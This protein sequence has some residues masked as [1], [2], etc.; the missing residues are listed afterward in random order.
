M[1]KKNTADIIYFFMRSLTTGQGMTGLT[2]E[3]VVSKDGAAQEVVAGPITELGR[4]QYRFEG[5]A[6][7][8]NGNSLGFI[9]YATGALDYDITIRTSPVSFSEIMTPTNVSKIGHV[10]QRSV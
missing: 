2:P 7:D 1:Y 3:G 5:T 8:F 4:G 9:F 6:D 10:I